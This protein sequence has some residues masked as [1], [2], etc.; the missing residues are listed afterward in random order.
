ML[1]EKGAQSPKSW[2]PSSREA[3]ARRPRGGI[4]RKKALNACEEMMGEKRFFETKCQFKQDY[5]TERES[6][7]DLSRSQVRAHSRTYF[8]K[9]FAVEI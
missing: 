8:V 4:G 3:G 2:V 1:A 7:N 5:D 6:R 9:E